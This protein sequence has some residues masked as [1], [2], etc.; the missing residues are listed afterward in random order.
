MFCY[1]KQKSIE[2]IREDKSEAFKRLSNKKDSQEY[3]EWFLKYNPANGKITKSTRLKKGKKI[4]KKYKKA[5][6]KT[7]KN[8]DF[9]Y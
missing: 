6:N 1:G 7:R 9:L 4:T 5:F 3:K 2:E 8:T